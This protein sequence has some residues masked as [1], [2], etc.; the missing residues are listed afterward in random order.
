MSGKDDGQQQ[1]QQE[2]PTTEITPAAT[3]ETSTR[4]EPK[5]KSPVASLL[6]FIYNSRRK[7]V[8]GRDAL[9]WGKLATFYTIFFFCVSCFFTGL[10]HL[11]ALSLDSRVPRYYNEDSTMTVRTSASIGLFAI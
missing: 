1:Q 3:V 9:N 4:V 2:V 11:F 8:L 7:T 6:N 10:L 5:K